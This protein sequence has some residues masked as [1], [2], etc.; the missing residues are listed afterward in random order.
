M[1]ILVFI[2][3]KN[4]F[5]ITKYYW[6]FK[7]LFYIILFF[8]LSLSI[9]NSSATFFRKIPVVLKITDKKTFLNLYDHN[10]LIYNECEYINDKINANEYY[11]IVGS[12]S[13]FCTQ[14]QNIRNL[15][16]NFNYFRPD[17][18]QNLQLDENLF[19]KHFREKLKFVIIPNNYKW[20]NYHIYRKTMSY[21]QSVKVKQK[22]ISEHFI[23][24][25]VLDFKN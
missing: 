4:F 14:K 17:H 3:S 25:E 15:I 1:P 24:I 22:K 10:K 23:L 11:I 18:R 20:N 16:N 2:S 6:K 8:S 19:N 9:I 5:S 12:N 13:F 7:S 21:L